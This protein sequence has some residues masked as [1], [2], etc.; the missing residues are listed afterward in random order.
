MNYFKM[1]T[2]FGFL[3]QL[4]FIKRKKDT[5]LIKNKNIAFL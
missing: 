4:L 2:D 1:Q 3:S 5:L